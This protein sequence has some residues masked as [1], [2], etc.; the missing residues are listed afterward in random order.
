MG[1]QGQSAVA[2][3]ARPSADFIVVQAHLALGLLQA[4]LNGPPPPCYPY[5]LRERGL[6][7]SPHAIAGTLTRLGQTAPDQHPGTPALGRRCL[8]G[9]LHPPPLIPTW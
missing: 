7:R 8:G 5:Q 6:W 2:I 3:P 4:R 9:P 1:Q